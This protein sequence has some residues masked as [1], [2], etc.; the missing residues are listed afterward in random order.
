RGERGAP[1]RDLRI[2]PALLPYLVLRTPGSRGPRP[3]DAL[4]LFLALGGVAAA[5]PAWQRDEPAYL[6]NVAPLIVAL[7]LSASMDGADVPPTRLEAARRVLRDLAARRAAAR[8][9]LIAYAGSSHLVLPP[10][11]DA[12]LLD[13]FAQALAT[14]L[15]ERPGRDADGAIALAAQAL[16]AERAGG[17]LL[18]LTDGADR[19]RMDAVRRQAQ[20]ARDMQVLV[21]AVGVNGIDTQALQE[22]ARAAGAALGSL[23]G[24]PDDQ[25]WIALH[26][27]A[28]FR[29][30]Q[31]AQSGPVHWK[32]AGYWLCWPLA[33]LALLAVRRGWSVAWSAGVLVVAM[34]GMPQP[35]RAD[36]LA[37]AFLTADQQ[38]RLA[39]EH[40][41]YD[42]AARH[43][44]DPYWK[45]RAAYEAGDYKAALAAFSTLPSAEGYFYVGNTQT[46]LHRYDAA[47][48]AYDR[49]LALKPGWQ[50]AV[51]NRGIVARLLA[52]MAQTQQDQPAEPPDQT[53]ADLTAQAGKMSQAPVAQAGSEEAWLRNL[54]LS[55]ARFLRSKFAAED[56]AAGA[57]P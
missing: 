40:G 39:F 32:D 48:A 19:A 15:I 22:L 11:D 8:T 5:G 24:G 29:A 51:V 3:I 12:G 9:G 35:A 55:P 14:G 1:G 2:A 27:Q 17:T 7:D 31:D 41:R 20:A 30:V 44:H 37:D 46:R 57:R 13:L 23:T 47:L 56:A 43:F 28:H 25:D 52:A 54:T 34:A 49:A 21:M 10:T 18:I 6:D 53:I 50:P 33:L 38:G 26:A 42:E 36:A 16:A 45:G 4:A